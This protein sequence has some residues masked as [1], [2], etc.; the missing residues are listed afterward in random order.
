MENINFTAV[1]L[2]GA[3]A[4]FWAVLI[5]R[6]IWSW[7]LSYITEGDKE[8]KVIIHCLSK[9]PIE[10]EDLFII[11]I[12]SCLYG[13][14]TAALSAIEKGY[15]FIYNLVGLSTLLI[16]VSVLKLSKYVYSI[17]KKLNNHTSNKDA[18]K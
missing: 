17:N 6:I 5:G 3:L 4:L 7:C 11:F 2:L 12:F 13:I 16:I 14:P 18:H 1:L 9:R 8:H 10:G 15:G